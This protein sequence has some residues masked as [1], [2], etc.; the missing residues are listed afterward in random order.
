MTTPGIEERVAALEA[1]LDTSTTATAQR[2]DS[3]ESTMNAR[4]NSLDARLNSFEARFM[5]LWGSTILAI[6]AG[7]IAIVIKL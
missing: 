1:N 7:V 5:G 6:V 3:L 2:L 4:F